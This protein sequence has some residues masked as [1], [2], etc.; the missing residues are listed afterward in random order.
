MNTVRQSNAKRRRG[1]DECRQKLADHINDRLGL[2]IE[3]INVR[4]NPQESDCYS[5]RFVQG[6]EAFFSKVFAKGLSDHSIGTFQ[7]LCREVGKSF[8]ATSTVEPSFSTIIGQLQEQNAVLS[9]Q[10]RETRSRLDAE[11]GRRIVSEEDNHRLRSSQALLENQVREQ[12]TEMGSLRGI[13]AKW[14]ADLE[15]AWPAL[16]NMRNY[17]SK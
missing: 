12:A 7:L 4:L 17:V 15:R 1:R 3:P 2:G 8:E 10:I 13:I 16:E 14:A 6:K 5:W 9:E 11:H